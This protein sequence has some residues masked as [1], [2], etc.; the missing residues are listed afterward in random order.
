MEFRKLTIVNQIHNVINI[1]RHDHRTGLPRGTLVTMLAMTEQPPEQTKCCDH[2][3]G[4]GIGITIIGATS[5]LPTCTQT[6]PINNGHQHAGNGGNDASN[7]L[8][9]AQKG[10]NDKGKGGK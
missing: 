5:C 2:G 8:H 9:V 1:Y 4:N 10:G 6:L 3:I 7:E